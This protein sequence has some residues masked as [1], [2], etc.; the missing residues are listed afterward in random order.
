MVGMVGGC[1]G[2][3]GGTDRQQG[4]CKG[5]GGEGMGIG[6]HQLNRQEQTCTPPS[7]RLV[8]T[9]ELSSGTTRLPVAWHGWRMMSIPTSTQTASARM[10][11]CIAS[12]QMLE[13]MLQDKM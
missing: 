8:M 1:V 7:T 2:V 10:M 12:N 11:F 4:M 5:D 6:N 3:M 13:T 9:M